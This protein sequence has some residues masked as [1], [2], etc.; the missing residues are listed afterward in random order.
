MVLFLGNALFAHHSD[1]QYASHYHR[2]FS[3]TLPTHATTFGF[4]FVNDFVYENNKAQLSFIIKQ[5]N[6]M[7]R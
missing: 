7:G 5:L 4:G 3:D 2:M 6:V 1:C